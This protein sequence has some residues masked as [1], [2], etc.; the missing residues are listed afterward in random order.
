M[1]LC[2]GFRVDLPSVF[3]KYGV[4]GAAVPLDLGFTLVV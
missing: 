4:D 2:P 1:E 3:S